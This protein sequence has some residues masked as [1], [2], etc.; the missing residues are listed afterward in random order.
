MTKFKITVRITRS[1][2]RVVEVIASSRLRHHSDPVMA[3]AA[4]F[5]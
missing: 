1:L 4:R 2:V 3:D 5:T